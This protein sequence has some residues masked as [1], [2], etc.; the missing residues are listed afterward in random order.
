MNIAEFPPEVLLEIF[1][2]KWWLWP[3]FA[4]VCKKFYSLFNSKEKIMNFA[5]MNNDIKY[6]IENIYYIENDAVR[7][8]LNL[9]FN[10]FGISEEQFWEMIKCLF[11]IHKLENELA[12]VSDLLLLMIDS[13][14]I[15]KYIWGEMANE[16][17]F[18]FNDKKL[19]FPSVKFNR[20]FA[21]L[22]RYYSLPVFFGCIQVWKIMSNFYNNTYFLVSTIIFPHGEKILQFNKNYKFI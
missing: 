13:E 20:S 17:L 4:A 22:C 5:A 19:Y 9:N 2:W 21:C 16:T 1:K 6:F 14:K 11:K 8:N 10:K 7:K 15:K 12:D 3:N 18:C